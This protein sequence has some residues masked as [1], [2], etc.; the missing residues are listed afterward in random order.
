MDLAAFIDWITSGGRCRAK[1]GADQSSGLQ[2]R[3][4]EPARGAPR[5]D[6][7]LG[8]EAGPSTQVGEVALHR[9]RSDAY[10]LG[11]VLD[12]PAG[13]DVGSKDVHLAL[14]RRPR[15]GAAQVPV[16]HANRLAAAIHSSRPSIG[17]SQ[18]QS[19][20]VCRRCQASRDEVAACHHDLLVDGM[21]KVRLGLRDVR[22]RAE[23]R[24]IEIWARPSSCNI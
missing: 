4:D 13:G 6:Q 1:P 2:G 19:A 17:H 23:G 5:V 11:G 21:Y 8:R 18:R 15:E 3:D 10:E 16:S 7:L 12:R 24:A 22:L 9:A 14:R 20:L